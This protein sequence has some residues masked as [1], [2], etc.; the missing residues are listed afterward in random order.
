MRETAQSLDIE[1]IL[2][3]LPHRYPFI[4]IDRI[5]DVQ[6]DLSLKGLKNVTMNEPFF[7][8]HFPDK[9]VMPGVLIIEGM[10]Q[11][12]CIFAYLSERNKIGN[13]LV[14]LAGMDKVRLRRQIV[15]G[16]QLI[17]EVKFL[18]QKAKIYKMEGKAY[19]ENELAAEAILLASFS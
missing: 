17:Y 11:T 15:P 3:L 13:S 6:P 16:D 10:A 14:F 8:G 1:G 18:K 5:Y 19:V 12:G 2:E 9:P 4:L 7:Q